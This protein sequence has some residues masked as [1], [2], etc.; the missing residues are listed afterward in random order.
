MR[1]ERSFQWPLTAGSVGLLEKQLTDFQL[2]CVHCWSL[3]STFHI[4]SFKPYFCLYLKRKLQH[5]HYINVNSHFY[6]SY[7]GKRVTFSRSKSK[8]L[9]R[10]EWNS[11]PL[12]ARSFLPT[13]GNS[14]PISVIYR[15]TL[16]SSSLLGR[17]LRGEEIK[18]DEMKGDGERWRESK[19]G[20]LVKSVAAPALDS[21]T[22]WLLPT[23][24]HL[25]L[26]TAKK[27]GQGHPE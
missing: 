11:W 25:T 22:K 13:L 7:R 14:L 1:E 8:S 20:F 2:L 16:E 27:F 9:V 12:T 24:P 4:W 19:R 6:I 10:Q 23:L 17:E 3:Y 26:T 21:F 15:L 18:G 5:S